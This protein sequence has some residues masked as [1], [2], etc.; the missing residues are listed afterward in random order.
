MAIGDLLWACPLCQAP[1]SI[2]QQSDGERCTSCGARW[3]RGPAGTIVAEPS[4]GAAEGAP[5][6]VAESAPPAAW[7][8]RLPVLEPGFPVEAAVE[9]RRGLAPEP[10]RL[11]GELVGWVERLADPVAGTLRLDADRLHFRAHH[12]GTESWVLEDVTGF[13]ISSRTLQ[14]KVRGREVMAL[15]FPGGS[16]RYWELVLS[17]ALRSHWRACERGAIREFQPCVVG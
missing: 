14:I 4:A 8:D 5:S 11:R 6:G 13:Q 17:A 1:Q 9:L 2:H 7:L 16:A 10:V 3:R 15:A 12:G